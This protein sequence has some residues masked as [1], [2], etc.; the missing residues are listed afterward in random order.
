[1]WRSFLLLPPVTSVALCWSPWVERLG[2]SPR[3]HGSPTVCVCALRSSPR[4]KYPCFASLPFRL[5]MF[6]PPSD[7]ISS[8]LWILYMYALPYTPQTY[9]GF[10]WRFLMP[11]HACLHFD[12]HPTCCPCPPLLP[13]LIHVSF[14][15]LLSTTSPMF[16]SM[17][18][19]I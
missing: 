18:R 1:M 11:V 6:F 5:A 14:L 7:Y 10:L 2:S 9:L 8:M 16:P 17:K 19:L 3:L 15:A 13:C 12:M 4:Y